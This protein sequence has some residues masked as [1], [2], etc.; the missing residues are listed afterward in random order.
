VH[1]FVEYVD[2]STLAQLGAPDMR[3]PIQVALAWPERPPGRSPSVDWRSLARLDFEPPDFERFPALAL[4]YRVIELGGIA[5][6]VMNAANE[7]AVQAFL[8]R[9]IPFGRITELTGEA[10][11][12]L[13]GDRRQAPLSSLAQALEADRAARA[14]VTDRLQHAPAHASSSR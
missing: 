12:E 11:G 9:R 1:G 2:G 4:A 5:G 14:F 3:T 7:R 8:D 6:A 13:V 10:V